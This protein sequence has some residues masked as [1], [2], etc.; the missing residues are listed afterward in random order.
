MLHCARRRGPHVCK[1][2][3]QLSSRRSCRRKRKQE[4][5]IF[6]SFFFQVGTHG[7]HVSS[8][9]KEREDALHNRAR[10]SQLAETRT[11]VRIVAIRQQRRA[12]V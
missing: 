2:K 8:A 5:T 9:N 12:E 3:S 6:C 7:A 1:K 10:N 4:R 11:C